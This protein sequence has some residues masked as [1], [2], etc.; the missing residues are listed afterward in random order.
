ML[1]VLVRFISRCIPQILDLHKQS[2]IS[3]GQ[4]ILLE[5]FKVLPEYNVPVIPPISPHQNMLFK[6]LLGCLC[7]FLLISTAS[8][9]D[10]I[11]PDPLDQDNIDPDPLEILT[12]QTPCGFQ[13]FKVVGNKEF[14][15]L[16]QKWPKWEKKNLTYRFFNSGYPERDRYHFSRAFD[17]WS[18]WT[19][20]TFTEVLYA[21]P[22]PTNEVDIDIVWYNREHYD[23]PVVEHRF[24][25][26]TGHAFPP[27]PGLNARG[28]IHLN[29]KWKFKGGRDFSPMALHMIGHS[30]GLPHGDK[31]TSA[32]FNKATP[33][34]CPT[35]DDVQRIQY[36]YG[37][38]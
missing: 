16:G 18:S 27:I 30:L 28:D 12:W 23:Y 17:Q 31:Y 5:I 11:D 6:A 7:I 38:K 24:E 21:G 2:R 14:Y 33:M 15:D 13:P 4:S 32:M 34:W 20:L 22:T 35:T 1:T 29:T 19:P 3:K 25:N 10:N 9:Q 8:S 36:L 37:K 26:V